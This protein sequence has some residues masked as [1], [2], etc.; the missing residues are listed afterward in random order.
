MNSLLAKTLIATA[1]IIRGTLASAF[2][3]LNTL[4]KS[5]TQGAMQFHQEGIAFA[6]EMGMNAKEAQ[7][8]TEVLTD[9]TE[10]LAMKYGV[11]AEQVKELQK[12]ISIATSRQLMLNESQA[13][14]FLQLNKLVGSSTVSKF[15][16]EMMNG[17]GGQ[18][19]TVQGAV[20]KAYATAAKSGLNAQKVSEKI[21]NNLSL[22]N[23]FSFRT[24]I[25]GLTRMAMQ[26]EKVGMNLSSIEGVANKF[27][28]IDDAIENSARLNMLGGNAAILG[29]NPLDMAYEA[30]YDP[31]ALMNRVTKMAQGAAKF[32][33]QK[34]IATVDPVMQ[35][36]LRNVAKA[37]GMNPEELVGSAKKQASNAFKEGNISSSYKNMGLSQEQIDF[38]IN[39]SDVKDG[40][41][42]FT[43]SNGENV[44]LSSGQAIDPK[45]IEEMMKYS[46]MS[47]REIME[48]NAKSLSSINEILK[49]IRDSIIAMFSKFIEGMFPDFQG[50]LKDFGAWAKNSL[51]PIAKNIG[52]AVRG[53]YDWFKENKE[54]FKTLANGILTFL[55]F[56]TEHWKILIGI[57]AGKKLY[58]IFNGAIKGLGSRGASAASGA[59]ATPSGVW[60]KAKQAYNNIRHPIPSNPSITRGTKWD[61]IKAGAKAGGKTLLKTGG[62]SLIGGLAG[63]AG[64]YAADTMAENG[65]IEKGGAAHTA[66]KAA[67]TAAEYAALGATIG[68][69]IPGVGTAAGAA[70]GG[71]AGA[72]K[73]FFDAKKVVNEESGTNSAIDNNGGAKAVQ[74][75]PHENGGFIT[76]GSI[77]IE[78]PIVGS[79]IG[80]STNSAKSV[81]STAQYGEAILNPTQQKNF[82]ALANGETPVKPKKSLGE[83]EY[84]YK[85]NRSQTSNVNGN[86]ITVKDF[87]INI[88]GTLKLDTGT[89]SKNIDAR[90]LLNNHAF[91]TEIKNKI[92]TSIN[93]GINNGRYLSDLAT[94]AGFSSPA[95]VYGKR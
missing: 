28:E 94:T 62:V 25:E 70:V 49:G 90:D 92:M 50:N 44:D 24:G 27:L 14:G 29:G 3:Y 73:G 43:T 37:I 30:N 15:T 66:L 13:E 7:A 93:E 80:S 52:E 41:V 40:K 75:V 72:I 22:A 17:M 64:N 46:G 57:F 89:Y 48:T 20:S 67:S 21:A 53:V 18:L 34:G 10:K 59:A 51:L 84:I 33:A 2:T 85:P 23:K 8:Y 31:E 11:A 69:I 83:A 95:S 6:R 78:K 81:I 87:N 58:D 36:Y 61:A 76:S 65:T 5:G 74:T 38:L 86:T 19:D 47:D 91:M 42:M 54:G 39:K 26:A 68:S 9:R 63:A 32:D 35:D 71:I 4:I 77:G 12:N 60:G 45:V 79:S 55:K 88:N 82:M 16:E 56:A 1:G